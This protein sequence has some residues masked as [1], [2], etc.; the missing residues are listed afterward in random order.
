MSARFP[1]C[2]LYRQRLVDHLP[3]RCPFAEDNPLLA[4]QHV[5]TRGWVGIA[6]H[7]LSSDAVD[8]AVGLDDLERSRVCCRCFRSLASHPQVRRLRAIA[9]AAESCDGLP[10]QSAVS[11]QCVEARGL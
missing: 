8:V 6:S 9:L 3:R 5:Q 10:S 1:M 4:I 2:R 11:S 7:P